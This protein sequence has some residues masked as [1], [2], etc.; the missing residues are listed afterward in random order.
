M[1]DKP[2]LN[3]KSDCLFMAEIEYCI[4][5]CWIDSRNGWYWVYGRAISSIEFC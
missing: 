3:F 4:I 5:I 1:G 2:M